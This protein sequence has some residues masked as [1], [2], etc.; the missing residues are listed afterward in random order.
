MNQ[1]SWLLYLGDVSERVSVACAVVSIFSGIAFACFFVASFC[2]D[3][4]D[5][6]R[7]ARIA[8]L[9]SLPPFLIFGIISLVCPSK[10]TVYAIA[11]SQVGEQVIK[12]PLAIKAEKA[13]EHWL[14]LQIAKV[15][16]P[17][18]KEGS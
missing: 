17:P 14:D 1:L 18:K 6:K 10:D 9:C 12:T 3:Y 5:E 8:W 2:M 15:P 11:A 13:V 4:K 16:D 7:Q